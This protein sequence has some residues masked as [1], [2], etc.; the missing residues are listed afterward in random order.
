MSLDANARYGLSF[1]NMT[2][3]GELVAAA[4]TYTQIVHRLI[5]TNT[6]GTDQTVTLSVTGGGGVSLPVAVKAGT[7]VDLDELLYNQAREGQSVTV[8]I[9]GGTVTVHVQYSLHKRVV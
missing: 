3:T 1:R 8:T 2:S 9:S 6:G 5:I 7:T 4:A